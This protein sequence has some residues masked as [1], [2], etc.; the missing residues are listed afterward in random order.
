MVGRYRYRLACYTWINPRNEATTSTVLKTVEDKDELAKPEDGSN[1]PDGARTWG[2]I[3]AVGA[4][5]NLTSPEA[6]VVPI[7]LT[8]LSQYFSFKAQKRQEK[9]LLKFLQTVEELGERVDKE[10]LR[11]EEFGYL[12]QRTM[13][14]WEKH[15]QEE[16][17]DAFQNIL[18]NSLTTEE[19]QGAVKE[20]FIALVDQMTV[21]HLRMVQILKD[22]YAQH[23]D[24]FDFGTTEFETLYNVGSADEAFPVYMIYPTLHDLASMGLISPVVNE[25]DVRMMDT[26]TDAMDIE[27]IKDERKNG[28][29]T[30]FGA[31]FISFIDSPDKVI[32]I[33]EEEYDPFNDHDIIY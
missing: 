6:S 2:I 11:T 19:V 17:L 1:V 31:L 20:R 5:F 25:E 13:E 22:G 10:Y 15:P 14:A 23:G 33:P 9:E 28:Q 16:K 27:R 3:T 30:E 29:L 18:A 32:E 8:A 21:L 12:F 26:L 7:L 4:S 24:W